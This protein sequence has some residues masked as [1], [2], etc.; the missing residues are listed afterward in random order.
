MFDE[1][2]HEPTAGLLRDR[3]VE[4]KVQVSRMTGSV[5]KDGGAAIVT[6]KN[7]FQFR[8]TIAGSR[9]EA[10]EQG[11]QALIEQDHLDLGLTRQSA[12]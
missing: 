1:Q 9:G 4:S 10:L 12:N 2:R 8:R 5:S 11:Y 3:I 7:P 6:M